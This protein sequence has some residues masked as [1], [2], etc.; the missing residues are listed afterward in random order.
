MQEIKGSEI[1]RKRR[2]WPMGLGAAVV[3]IMLASG[4]AVWAMQGGAGA[5]SSGKVDTPVNFGLML[6][7]R[8]VSHNSLERKI[9]PPKTPLQAV[10]GRPV[11]SGKKPGVLYIGADYC[12]YCASLRWPL[13]VALLRFGRLNGLRYMRSS[14][15]DAYPNTITF[16]FH[17]ANFRSRYLGFESVE[18]YDRSQQPLEQPTSSQMAI[19]K[20][21]D[22]APYTKVPGALPFLYLG[23]QYLESG[24]PFIPSSLKG[25]SWKQAA[26]QLKR[27]GTKLRKQVLGTA[28]L[29]TAAM[30]KLTK[31]QPANVCNTAAI[32]AASASLPGA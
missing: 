25:L 21:F 9:K 31:G 29:Y 30:C 10:S 24:A 27:P 26:Q 11:N 28:N 15:S 22:A 13:V 3:T 14:S 4:V 12:P 8:K 6:T 32:K 16:S 20:K 18:L 7:L 1:E 17:G 5:A 2:V 19:L 23:G